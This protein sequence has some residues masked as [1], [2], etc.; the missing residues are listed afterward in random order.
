VK[1]SA[2]PRS[3]TTRQHLPAQNRSLERGLEI[4]RAFRPGTDLLGNGDIAEKTGIARATVSRLTQTLVHAGMLEYDRSARAYRVGVATLSLALA[5]R[6]SNPVLQTA[7]PLMRQ[8]SERLRVNVGLA[9][10]DRQD[11]VY[12]ESIRY[13]RRPA[14][15][16][17]VSGQRIPIEL[18][19]LGRA[20]L[21]AAPA[22]ER[23]AFLAIL[24]TRNPARAKMLERQILEAVESVRVNG[25]CAAAWQLDVVAVATPIVLPDSPIYALNMSVAGRDPLV[26][27]VT[28]LRGPLLE[29]RGAIV[30]TLMSQ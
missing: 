13:N 3:S 19:S 15:R 8:A 23:D 7:M 6:A 1:G 26:T 4:L 27:V 28:T 25:F 22:Q 10:P 2:K 16:T 12:L 9:T 11:M 30:E 14:L 24:Q 5:M 21:A 29:L 17:V 20:Y 18:T